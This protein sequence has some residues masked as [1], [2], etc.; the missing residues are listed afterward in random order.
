VIPIIFALAIMMFPGMVAHFLAGVG[1]AVGEIAQSVGSFFE[2]PW[3]YGIFYFVLVVLFTFFYTAVTFDPKAISSNLQKM[4]G[5]IPGIRP[6]ESTANFLY[7]ILHRILVIGAL[8]LA[9]IAVMPSIIAGVTGI[10]VFRFFV[11]G[12]ALLIIVSV[13][14]ETMRQ[15]NA[16]LQMREYETF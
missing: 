4:G 5:F 9:T 15:I 14:L 1:G 16:Q 3:V 12:T 7:Y 10:T 11:G 6:G 13:V 2:N 8:F